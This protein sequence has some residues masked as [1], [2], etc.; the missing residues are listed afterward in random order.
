MVVV[1]SKVGNASMIKAFPAAYRRAAR[2][3]CSLGKAVEF[4]SAEIS[5]AHGF[6]QLRHFSVAGVAPA[7]TATASRLRGICK[8]RFLFSRS[9]ASTQARR[10]PAGIPI[11][12][13]NEGHNESIESK[14]LLHTV[15]L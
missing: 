3:A 13:L 15:I 9:P 10:K 5:L 8:T 7:Q 2:E 14:Q 6:E 1:A 12:P 4:G 11:V